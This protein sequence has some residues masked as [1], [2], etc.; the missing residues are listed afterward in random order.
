MQSKYNISVNR[1]AWS[2]AS[3]NQIKPIH[4]LWGLLEIIAIFFMY[5]GFMW[6]MGTKLDAAP[7][8]VPLLRGIIIASCVYVLW[9]SPT[10]LHKD[11]LEIR[12]LTWSRSGAKTSHSRSKE[13]LSY[14]FFT[15]TIA[16]VLILWAWQLD[17][18]RVT[19]ANWEAFLIRLS[20]Y[21]LYAFIQ[22]CLF[23]G[24]IFNRLRHVIPMTDRNTTR[25]QHRFQVAMASASCFALF[26]LPNT[27][28]MALTL[29][30]GFGWGWIFYKYPSIFLLTISH[31]LLG[32]ILN[33][34]VQ[35]HMR[36]GP[37]YYHPDLFFLRN[38]IPGLQQ[39]TRSLF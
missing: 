18:S 8:S 21:S 22:V 10:Y 25:S 29:I 13:F 39:L 5:Q 38:V 7:W 36:V 19:Q 14:T 11:T 34:V 4:P 24:F 17:P 30:A 28:L 33:Q 20:G 35:L 16:L 1:P 32:N 12:G 23:Y 37:Y 15:I 26:H 27:P 31:A 3:Y 2:L 6:G 9:F